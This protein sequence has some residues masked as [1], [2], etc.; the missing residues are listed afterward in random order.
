MKNSKKNFSQSMR[1]FLR[2]GFMLYAAANNCFPMN[3]DL[4]ELYRQSIDEETN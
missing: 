4:M 2:D 1:S 3:V